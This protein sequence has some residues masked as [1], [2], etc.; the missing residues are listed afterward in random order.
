MNR[1]GQLTFSLYTILVPLS[2]V[3]LMWVVFWFEIRFNY[4]FNNFGVQPQ[5]LKG[6]R[7]IIFSPFIHSDLS[8][9][10]HNTLPIL[11][12][13]T[14]LFYFYRSKAIKIMIFGLL[15]TGL[16]TWLIARPSNHIGASGVIYFL[17]SFLFFKGI[18]S[19]HY[20]LIALSLVVI[21]IY[22]SLIW[23]TLPN[24]VAENV[25]WE[26]HLSGLLTGIFGALIFKGVSLKKE[27]FIW[28]KPDY[29]EEE[30]EFMSHFDESGNFVEKTETEDE[31]L[32]IEYHYI[33]NKKDS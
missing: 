20:R 3:L 18:W 13:G 31:D 32:D 2:F 25:S 22:G 23:G 11:I 30:D 15:I 5:T 6:L 10:W 33:E 16:I 26:G 7:G 24:A 12:L 14:A 21:F 19:K 9:L 29:N 28:E 4:N 17:S 8:H 27:K 1:N